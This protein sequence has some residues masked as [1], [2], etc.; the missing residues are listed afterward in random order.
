MSKRLVFIHPSA[1]VAPDAKIGPG[2]KIWHEAQVREGAVVGEECVLGK[3]AYVDERVRIGDRCKLQNGVSV[4]HGFT[5]ESG[6]FLGPGVM[7]LNDK[8]P[9]AI[10]LDGSVKTDADWEVAAGVI[11]HGASVG[12]GAIV[13]PGVRIGSMA[14]VGAG[15]VVTRDVPERGIVAGNPAKLRGFACDCG[16]PLAKRGARWECAQD[17]RDYEIASES[18][19]G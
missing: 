6:V 11:E 4:F 9:R 17:G 8:H 13:L 7:L 12:G 3:G 15:A 10:N 1:D 14:I 16:R 18:G 5:V 19:H 2:T